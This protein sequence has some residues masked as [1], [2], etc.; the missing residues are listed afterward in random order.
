METDGNA[1]LGCVNMIQPVWRPGE[2]IRRVS[3]PTFE[4]RMPGEPWREDRRPEI[5]R[6]SV[7][8]AGE[9]EVT[10]RG[11]AWLVQPPQTNCKHFHQVIGPSRRPD[12][13]KIKPVKL[14]IEHISDKTAEKDEMTCRICANVVQ[15]PANISKRHLDVYRPIRWCGQVKSQPR[16]VKR[17]E[18]SGRTYLKRVN[19]LQSIWRPKKDKRRLE[20]LT[21]K[22]RM[23]GEPWRDVG[24]HRWAPARVAISTSI[25]ARCDLPNRAMTWMSRKQTHL[26]I[27]KS[28][29]PFELDTFICNIYCI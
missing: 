13:I 3:K 27:N 22:S 10:Y 12:R 25:W 7:N 14:R 11:C 1:H 28:Q 4:F 6:I 2:R 5:E 18:R 29:I 20:G 19:T 26:H 23:L 24:D 8:Q 9:D 15:P 21:F 16:N 17:M